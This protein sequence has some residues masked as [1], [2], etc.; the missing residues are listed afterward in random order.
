[1]STLLVLGCGRPADP[2][3]AENTPEPTVAETSAPEVVAD[4]K[5]VPAP[6][7]LEPL[8]DP[9]GEE[10]LYSISQVMEYAH[11]NK[12]YR[13]LFSPPVD[14]AVAER[15]ITLYQSLPKQSSPKGDPD[16]WTTRAEALASS[17]EG[18]INGDADAGKA[19]RKAVNCNSCHSRHKP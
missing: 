4:E 19:F 13:E 3:M 8:P 16:D 15:L 11:K 18:V 1:M 5:P 9:E 12:L 17:A 6:V 2:P 14:E 7:E 10:G